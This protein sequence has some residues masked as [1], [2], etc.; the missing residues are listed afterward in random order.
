MEGTLWTGVPR[1]GGGFWSWMEKLR[2]RCDRGVSYE[3]LAYATMAG[4]ASAIGVCSSRRTGRCRGCG[5]AAPSVCILDRGWD[6]KRHPNG[7]TAASDLRP[8]RLDRLSQVAPRL[9]STTQPVR[10]AAAK[11]P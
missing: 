9:H 6:R 5:D 11:P 8:V 10:T 2:R 7:N 3:G 1:S 4:L